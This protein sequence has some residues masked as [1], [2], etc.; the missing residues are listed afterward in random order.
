MNDRLENSRV[1]GPG[2]SKFRPPQ[3]L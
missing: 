1:S 2:S 3:A